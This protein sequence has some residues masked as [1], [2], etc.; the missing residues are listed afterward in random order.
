MI[1]SDAMLWRMIWKE[2]R[3]Q[4]GYWLVIA[5]FSI[6]LM[7]LFLGLLDANDS[8]RILAP[9]TIAVSLPAVYALGCAAVAFAA[10]REDGTIEMLQI[11]AARTSRVY[12]GKVSFSFVSTLA[13]LVL[14][15]FVALILTLGNPI[16][17]PVVAAEFQEQALATLAMIVQFLAWGYFFSALCKKALT[18]V[19]LTA[20]APFVVAMSTSTLWF[21]QPGFSVRNWAAG[22]SLVVPLVA[23]AYILVQRTM[24]GRSLGW[25]LPKLARRS[26]SAVNPL[27]RLAAVKE[28]SPTWRRTLQRLMWLEFR[29]V[30]SIGHILW[31][32]AF[33]VMVFFPLLAIGSNV[34][35][36][37]GVIG[38]GGIVT[39]PLFM[40][41]WTFQAEAGRRIRFLADHGLSPQVVW[42]SKQLVW[43]LLTV[44][45]TFPFVVA[46]AIG[47]AHD[48]PRFQQPTTSMFHEGVPGASATTYV[49]LLAC[50]AYGAGQFVSMLIAR[51]VT[52]GFVGFALFGMLAPWTWLMIKLQVPVV[53]SV[54]PV[55]VVLIATTCRWSRNWLL[56][57]AT[58][59]SWLKLAGLLGLSVAL[60]WA[61]IGVFRVYEVPHPDFVDEIAPLR[62]A[63]GLA[64]TRPEAETATLYRQALADFKWWDKGTE[65]R[66]VAAQQTVFKGWESAI[67]GWD[68]ATE[69]EKRLLAE[70]QG[71]LHEGLAAT[72]RT[73][74]AFNDP[75]GPISVLY[76]YSDPP[77]AIFMQLPTLILL[78][79]RELE[80][81]G[82]LD[83]ALDRY[84]AVLRLSRHLANRGTMREWGVGAAVEA[85]VG[86]WIVVWA[87]HPDQTAER[88]KAAAM[89]VDQ[90]MAQ[91]PSLRDALLTQQFMVRKA[92]RDDWAQFLP[93]HRN[94]EPE[95]RSRSTL[96]VFGRICPWEHARGLRVFD[97]VG[98]A[99]VQC[100]HVVEQALKTPGL[101]IQ[102]LAQ[103][104]GAVPAAEDPTYAGILRQFPGIGA[105]QFAGDFFA[106]Q[107]AWAGDLERV[108]WNWLKTTYPLNE[109]LNESDL[110]V[111]WQTRLRRELSLRMMQLQLKLV[112]FKKAHG[113]YPNQLDQL[114]NLAFGIAIDPYTG[115]EFGYRREGFPFAIHT[116]DGWHSTREFVQ[117]GQP[118]V[119]SAGPNDVHRFAP[120]MEVIM[121]KGADGNP[122]QVHIPRDAETTALVFPLP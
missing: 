64:I 106:R 66:P 61:G 76:Q 78:S 83:E 114:D 22:M 91:F 57:Q 112:A 38:F 87:A 23:V 93:K 100:L 111:I 14:L 89:R 25:S 27:D 33:Y 115:A 107:G 50:L 84:V 44:A 62:E 28:R 36:G 16:G 6:G 90:E 101:D 46:V 45:L 88:I 42:L 121:Q 96:T 52:A 99:E 29:H 116:K 9:W 110:Q 79:A 30:L 32:G 55:F 120:A 108:P 4:R 54:V 118:I 75:T 3:A 49:T 104:A 48:A 20:A 11:M 72:S 82:R 65:Q 35:A 97:L 122:I 7:L 1:L 31:I 51:G 26:R 13:M 98:A 85:M 67:N 95:A 80:S 17:P 70:N 113:E 40:G 56:E 74:G 5:G 73:A 105:N 58:A 53:L 109:T 2:Y 86:N 117:A 12:W 43:G 119:W 18:A 81:Q 68:Y 92:Y 103:Q 69:S 15:L 47:N 8:Q 63:H 19:C 102:L 94:P 24:A 77:V 37:A 34:G 21:Q 10:E 39:I 71:S 41:V 60:V 59:K